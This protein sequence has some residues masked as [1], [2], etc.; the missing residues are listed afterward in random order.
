MRLNDGMPV[1]HASISIV[2]PRGERLR[3][4]GAAERVA[5]ALLADVGGGREWWIWN[6][7]AR[8]GHLRVALT[9]AEY[10]AMPPGCAAFD[11]GPSGP[12]RPRTRRP[13]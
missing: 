11:A 10:A 2:S 3:S 5:V 7:R 4:P 1:W 8:V 6:P 13:A 12:Q 9:T